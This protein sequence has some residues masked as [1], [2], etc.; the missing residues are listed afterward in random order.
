VRVKQA[1]FSGITSGK[2]FV[3]L[4]H[5]TRPEINR[6]CPQPYT[7]AMAWALYTFRDD[8]PLSALELCQYLDICGTASPT[9]N[10]QWEDCY[11]KNPGK[12]NSMVSN[13]RDM[14]CSRGVNHNPPGGRIRWTTVPS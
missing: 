1:K 9:R 6:W 7:R 11:E 5:P 4:V 14:L 8:P 10:L 3:R 12:I 2:P 13:L